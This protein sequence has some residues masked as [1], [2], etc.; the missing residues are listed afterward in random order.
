MIGNQTF[1]LWQQQLGRRLSFWSSEGSVE[2]LAGAG[3]RWRM[4]L[5]GCPAQLAGWAVAEGVSCRPPLGTRTRPSPAGQPSAPRTSPVRCPA[6]LTHPALAARLCWDQR[7]QTA[8][9]AQ[10]CWYKN[11]TSGGINKLFLCIRGGHA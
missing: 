11:N 9:D 10:S 2:V 4:A 5:P 8:T 6:G 3:W 7:Q 1:L